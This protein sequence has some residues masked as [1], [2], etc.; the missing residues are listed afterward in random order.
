MP[1][2]Q[3]RAAQS[4]QRGKEAAAMVESGKKL[5]SVRKFI[6]EQGDKEA[7]GRRINATIGKAAGFDSDPVKLHDGG[8]VPK[9]G[10][11]SLEKDETVIPKDGHISTVLTEA[12]ASAQHE[13]EGLARSGRWERLDDGSFL[14]Y[15]TCDG[16]E[17]PK[18]SKDLKFSAPDL[19]EFK[20][21]LDNFV[22]GEKDEDE[23]PDKKEMPS[24]AM[25]GLV[26]EKGMVEPGEFVIPANTVAGLQGGLGA[27]PKPEPIFKK[28]MTFAPSAAPEPMPKERM[29]RQIF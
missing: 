15:F 17:E 9:T 22:G 12:L 3:A 27:K 5:S 20:E 18:V 24:Y 8:V 28:P 11:Y 1:D 25:G 13:S 6:A 14:V 19:D 21:L 2:E 29:P 10:V 16:G 7:E 23:K 4:K 26:T